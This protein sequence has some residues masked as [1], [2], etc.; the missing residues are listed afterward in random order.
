MSGAKRV[1]ELEE[2]R[3]RR[4][5]DIAVLARV[6]NRCELHDDVLLCGEKDVTD[7]YKLGN[8]MRKRDAALQDVFPTGK[9]LTD[10]IKAAD[11]E[12]A[13]D[14]CPRCDKLMERD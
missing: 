7:A 13:L 14:D 9:H 8:Y 11:E 4:A 2:E 1:I 10:A 6:I 5:I 12:V 3:R